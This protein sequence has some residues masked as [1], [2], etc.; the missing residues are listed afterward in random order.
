MARSAGQSIPSY[1]KHRPSGQAVCTIGG[2]DHYLGP[3]GSKAS[4]I[5]YDRLI[6]E[7]LASGR[8]PSF[9]TANI[10]VA[11]LLV[12]Y[13][14]H[15][16]SYYG[17]K[18]KKEYQHYRRVSRPLNQLYRRTA[19]SEFGPVANVKIEIAGLIAGS[20]F[21]QINVASQISLDGV[22]DVAFID[23][24][25]PTAGDTFEIIT[26]ANILGE[27]EAINLP[28]LAGDLLWFINQTATTLEL[29]STYAADF[30][31]N[32]SVDNLDFGAWEG[33]FGSAS[34]VH[35]TGDANTDTVAN[36]FDFL[37]WQQQFGNTGGA[38]L[39][40]VTVTPEPSSLLLASLAGLIFGCRRRRI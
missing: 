20:E 15:A 10:S 28:A 18:S 1:R 6:T 36:G 16:K 21:D 17:D 3:H 23:G 35:M 37:T 8:L 22:L 26:A 7:W 33:G 9:V 29:V 32:G 12:A 13:L 25:V 30:D 40:A 24:F 39:A 31:E 34:A 27:F 14:R 19:A 38:P 5:E 2:K 4:R 11:E